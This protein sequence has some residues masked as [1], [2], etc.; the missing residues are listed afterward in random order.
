MK[1]GWMACVA[2]M[3]FGAGWGRYWVQGTKRCPKYL[4]SPDA[5][6]IFQAKYQGISP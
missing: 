3:V 6:L 2:I 1:L 4:N 5:V